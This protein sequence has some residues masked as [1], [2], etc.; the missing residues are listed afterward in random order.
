M[1]RPQA[2][3]ERPIPPD[4]SRLQQLEA[5]EEL[6]KRRMEKPQAPT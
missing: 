4:L 1:S 2:V 5:L 6:C 3:T